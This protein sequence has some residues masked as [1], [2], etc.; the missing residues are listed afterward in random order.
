MSYVYHL[1]DN[2]VFVFMMKKDFF[3]VSRAKLAVFCRSCEDSVSCGFYRTCLM[4]V[5]MSGVC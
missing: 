2:G 1:R 4:D 5:Y 3:N